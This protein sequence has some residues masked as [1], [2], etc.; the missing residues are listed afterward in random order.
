MKYFDEFY[1]HFQTHVDVSPPATN[2][3]NHSSK[4]EELN[5][6]ILGRGV[7]A[8]TLKDQ[9]FI[10]KSCKCTKA[11]KVMSTELDSVLDN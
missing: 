9:L 7:L 3:V 5:F 4:I 11:L 1:F 10:T 8:K 2:L 6:V